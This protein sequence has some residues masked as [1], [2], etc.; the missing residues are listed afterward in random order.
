MAGETLRLEQRAETAATEATA[1][2][3]AA[4]SVKVDTNSRL[5]VIAEQLA[6]VDTSVEARAEMAASRVSTWGRL[7]R[8]VGGVARGA[9]GVVRRPVD[10]V[11]GFVARRRGREGS[12]G[13]RRAP[14]GTINDEEYS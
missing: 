12:D 3:A 14:S 4:K 5:A 1:A 10:G 7:T 8:A 6:A 11:R 13:D 9:A 2:A